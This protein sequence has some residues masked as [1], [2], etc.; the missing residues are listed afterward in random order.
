MTPCFLSSKL[1]FTDGE[2]SSLTVMRASAGESGGRLAHVSF[3]SPAVADHGYQRGCE[4]HF[5]GNL[6]RMQTLGN[7][8][9]PCIARYLTEG[10]GTNGPSIFEHRIG[11]L[12][13]LSIIHK[14]VKLAQISSAYKRFVRDDRYE[15]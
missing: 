1:K 9:A 4:P 5:R 12:Q 10:S 7:R 8:L 15:L 14:M 11:F 13:N 2:G 6:P 3:S